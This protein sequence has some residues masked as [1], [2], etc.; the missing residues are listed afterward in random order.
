MKFYALK[1]ECPSCGKAFV[2]GGSRE[3]DLLRWCQFAVDC[4]HCSGRTQIQAVQSVS[5]SGNFSRPS[6]KNSV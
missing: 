5:L 2:V 4:P 3:H 1:V 6:L